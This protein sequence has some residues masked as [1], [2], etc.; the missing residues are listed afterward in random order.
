[1]DI[2][3][4]PCLLAFLVVLEELFWPQF[5]TLLADKAACFSSNTLKLS[6]YRKYWL[7]MVNGFLMLG[8]AK[9]LV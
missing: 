1:M 2:E 3:D 4:F 6:S 7:M 8:S 5:G 9:V